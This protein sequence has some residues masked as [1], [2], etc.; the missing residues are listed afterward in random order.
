VRQTRS[1]PLATL[2]AASTLVALGATVSTPADA[3]ER[4]VLTGESATIWNLAGEMLLVAGTGSDVVVEVTRG[5]SDGSRLSVS[6]S[7][8][9]LKV[10]YPDDEIVYRGANERWR[11]STTLRV[12]DDGTFGGSWDDGGRRVR[13]RTSGTG[14]EAHADLRIQ[15]PKGKRLE[16]HLA[17]GEVTIENVDGDL[18]IDVH[19]ASIRAT[20]TKGRLVADAGSGSVRVENGQGELDVDTGSGSTTVLGF[21]G[22]SIDIDAGSGSIEVRDVTAERVSVDVGSGSVRAE[23]IGADDVQID[24]GSGGV[25]LWLTKV[26]RSTNV[27]TGSGSVRLEL[28]ATASADLDIETGS[29]GISSD[30]A[31]RMDQVRRNELRGRIGE[32]GSRI[33]VSTGSGGVRLIKR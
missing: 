28:P 32:G 30:F 26:P 3:Q 21:T 10:R 31:V 20:G 13:V 9:Q 6:A 1:R 23:S 7:G 29:G 2:F 14:L 5:G 8:G 17:L 15:V 22:R 12:R 19:S 33:T 18:R 24:T 25:D 27:D 4:H 16:V 11:S